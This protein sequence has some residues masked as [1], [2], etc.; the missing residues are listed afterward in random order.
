[1]LTPSTFRQWLRVIPGSGAGSGTLLPLR[2]LVEDHLAGLT[3]I[4]LQIVPVRPCLN[5]CQFNLTGSFVAVW[6]NQVGVIRKLV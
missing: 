3:A 2:R 4:Q 1:M 5:I 6:D